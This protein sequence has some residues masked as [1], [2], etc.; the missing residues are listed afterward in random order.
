LGFYQWI[1]FLG[2]AFFFFY[3]F[4]KCRDYLWRWCKGR[5]NYKFFGT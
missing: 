2:V 5:F 1:L 3:L 4:H